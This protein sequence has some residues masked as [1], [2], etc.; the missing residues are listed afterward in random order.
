[1]KNENLFGRLAVATAILLSTTAIA[2]T[3]EWATSSSMR[4]VDKSQ[5]RKIVIAAANMRTGV[6][7]ERL[8]LLSGEGNTDKKITASL[9]AGATTLLNMKAGTGVEID[10]ASR[11]PINEHLKQEDA[12]K[13]AAEA[14][15]LLIARLKLAGLDVQGPQAVA[16]AEFYKTVS[17]EE[18]T[19]TDA[20]VKKGGLF[21]TGYFYGMYRTPVAG[22]KYR[23]TSLMGA[24]GGNNDFYGKAREAA[25]TGTALE[26]N[27]GFYNDKKVF[28]VFNLSVSLYGRHANASSDSLLLSSTLKNPTALTVP[29]GGKDA[30]AYWTAM[31]PQFETLFDAL[32]KQ[33]VDGYAES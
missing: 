12:E 30:Y 25:K 20:E 10:F 21:K 2:Q 29:S 4:Y 5:D 16:A 9:L 14:L 6:S 24:F 28:G 22:L 3:A 27:L 7:L 23:P 13:I 18:K 31:K 19:T 8:T 1:M 17:G 15:D 11:E 26:L 33:I 32:A